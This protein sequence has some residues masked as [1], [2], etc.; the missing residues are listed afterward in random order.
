MNSHLKLLNILDRVR[1]CLPC[2]LEYVLRC[3]IVGT[4]ALGMSNTFALIRILILFPLYHTF[5]SIYLCPP[6]YLCVPL[7][8]SALSRESTIKSGHELLGPGEMLFQ[9]PQ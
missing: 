4:S 3:L 6:L 7:H 1:N 9:M 2:H 8:P 5:M